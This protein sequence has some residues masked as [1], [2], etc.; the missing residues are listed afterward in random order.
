MGEI[1]GRLWGSGKGLSNFGDM[2][3]NFAFQPALRDGA[4]VAAIGAFWMRPD[5]KDFPGLGINL[6]D[7]FDHCTVNRML[8]HHDITRLER[9]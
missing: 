2:P 8:E 9:T 6:L 5:D 4:K 7:L 3:E 1:G